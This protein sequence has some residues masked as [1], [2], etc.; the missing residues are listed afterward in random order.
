MSELS[1]VRERIEDAVR[2]FQQIDSVVLTTFNLDGDF[3]ETN[4]FPTIFGI[5]GS[6][7]GR[8]AALHERLARI[9]C[10]VFYDPTTKPR[11]SGRY[12]YVAQPVPIVENFFHPKLVIIA[13]QSYDEREWVYLAV[14]SAN[15]SYSGWGRNAESFGETWIQTK[16]QQPWATL[17]GFFKWLDSYCTMPEKRG[18]I[19]IALDTLNGM[20]DSKR[21]KNDPKA[22]WSNSLYARFYVSTV[23]THGFAAFLKERR[24]RRP[25]QLWAYSPYWSDVANQVE[26]FNAT[27]TVLVPAHTTTDR[28]NAS[29]GLSKNDFSR[30]NNSTEVCRNSLDSTGRFWHMKAYWLCYGQR[31]IVAV[32]SCNFT[33]AGLTGGENS[34]VE[35]MLVF[36]NDEF[37]CFPDVEES[38]GE[39]DLPDEPEVEEGTPNSVSIAIVVAWDW[40][41]QSWKWWL[42]P[43][44]N[45]SDFE[46]DLPNLSPFRINSPTGK[47][48]GTQPPRGSKFKISFQESG[49]DVQWEGLVVELNLSLSH[50]T[51]GIPLSANEIL[52]SWR[53]ITPPWSRKRGESDEIDSGEDEGLQET[54]EAAFDAVNLYD[55]YRSTQ[56]LREKLVKESQQSVQRSYLIGRSDSAMSLV[57]L[58][59]S[60]QQAP[61]VRFLVLNELCS[62]FREWSHLFNEE[63]E[64]LNQVIE[65]TQEVQQTV[66]ERL[67]QELPDHLQIMSDSMLNWFLHE[68]CNMDLK[69][70]R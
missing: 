11:I 34:N 44:S 66:S 24:A 27:H 20:P 14:S 50:R 65:L 63:V 39:S 19:T 70:K 45:Q 32:G 69:N 22:P 10:T 31:A 52:E 41:E 51:Y 53:G 37:D 49:E 40:Q 33:H 35:A 9:P 58:A 59:E 43:S 30:L 4:V 23:N 64:I 57:L 1:T 7:A 42:K 28:G 46:L 55:L 68:L 21:V 2:Y 38:I 6:G 36:D 12:R 62:V 8:I 5:E 56:A 3:L 48:T 54:A 26:A 25:D 18:A 60:D 16:R 29:Y 61:V 13:G 17:V 47:R 67:R 15:L